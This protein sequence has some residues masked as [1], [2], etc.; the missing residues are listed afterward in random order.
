MA[1]T[2]VFDWM[3]GETSIPFIEGRFVYFYHQISKWKTTKR[4][5]AS[6]S[7]LN[8]DKYLNQF[9]GKILCP[10]VLELLFCLGGDQ[11]GS[12]RWNVTILEFTT[13][14]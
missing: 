8:S 9:A 11:I 4:L 7:S 14:Q 2:Q 13:L 1:V 6:H 5:L 3:N 10:R 12:R